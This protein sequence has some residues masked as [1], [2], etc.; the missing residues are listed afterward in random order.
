MTW[1][2]A[3]LYMFKANQ[4]DQAAAAILAKHGAQ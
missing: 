1:G 3:Y 2:M 4:F